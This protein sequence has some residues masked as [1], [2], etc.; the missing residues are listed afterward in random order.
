[1]NLSMLRE[2]DGTCLLDVAHIFTAN[3]YCYYF[4]T[5]ADYFVFVLRGHDIFGRVFPLIRR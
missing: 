5:S 3:Q 1:M 4:S 2:C